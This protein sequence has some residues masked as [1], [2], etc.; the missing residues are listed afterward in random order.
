MGPDGRA[1][2]VGTLGEWDSTGTDSEMSERGR[3][4]VMALIRQEGE[5]WYETVRRGWRVVWK[6]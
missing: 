3:A 5:V 4:F 2:K 6:R 1:C